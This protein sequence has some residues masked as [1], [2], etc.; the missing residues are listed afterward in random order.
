MQCSVYYANI[1]I[2]ETINGWCSELHVTWVWSTR[3][4][5]RTSGE[6]W[7]GLGSSQNVASEL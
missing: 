4:G 7:T 2:E 1:A 6:I 3:A 5:F